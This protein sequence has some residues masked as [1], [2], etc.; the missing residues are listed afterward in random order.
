MKIA[1]I[2]GGS[3]YT[4]ELVNG[5]LARRTALPVDE[6]WLMDIDSE[7]L[8]IVGGFAQRMVAAQ[9]SDLRVMLTTDRREAIR[10]ASYVLT[11][12][13][14]G[15]MAARR[16]DEYL[17]HRHGLIGQETTG[18]G[19]MAKAL[20]TIPV[21][22]DIAR[23]MRELAPGALLVNF[24]NPAGLV[25]EALFRHAPDVPAVGLCN[26]PYNA[27]MDVLKTLQ[28]YDGPP[29]A[30]ERAVLTTLGLNHLS[31][32]TG[33]TLDGED[34]WPQ[35]LAAYQAE[36]RAAADPEWSPD[37][38]AS[39][40]AIPGHYLHYFYDPARMLATQ[41]AWP[42]SRAEAVME[43]EADL[44]R[45]YAEPERVEPPADLMLRGGAYYSTV[46][47]QLLNAHFN[48]L[49]EIH[50]V[51]VRHNGAVP[52][53][54]ADWVLELPSRVDAAGIHPLPTPP[55][56]AVCAALVGQIKAYELLTV[57][58]AV[59]GDRRAAYQA[60]LAHPL[61]PPADQIPAVL[62]DLLET[63]RAYLPQFFAPDA[64]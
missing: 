31:W 14:V 1:V 36:L 22:L 55:L 35:V 19:G 24:T 43:I 45:Q 23:I 26:I 59:T 52:G 37:L 61:G 17:G 8:A 28:G 12:L 57:E 3:T 5:L 33:L 48:D 46:A 49:G 13:R 4:P 44:L 64:S 42:P 34:H 62:D 54:P 41:A 39:L 18:I 15:Q 32:H 30:P 11:Q 50:T 29:I 63:H 9:G 16:A 47:T 25:T 58:A 40:E 51:N 20:R 6:L 27:K 60:M 38:I 21:I 10:G 7:R 56:P 2:G 53:W